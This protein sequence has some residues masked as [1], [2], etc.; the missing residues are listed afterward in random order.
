MAVWE[1]VAVQRV[2]LVECIVVRSTTKQHEEQ[3]LMGGRIGQLGKATVG[4]FYLARSE[5]VYKSFFFV[6]SVCSTGVCRSGL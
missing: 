6:G 1:I 2:R 3:T 4:Y 5:Q